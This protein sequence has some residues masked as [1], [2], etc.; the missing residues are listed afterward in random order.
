MLTCLLTCLRSKDGTEGPQAGPHVDQATWWAMHPRVPRGQRD[1]AYARGYMDRISGE[2][3]AGNA[4]LRQAEELVRSLTGVKSASVR[5][6][7]DGELAEIRV[8]AEP[9]AA[10]AEIVRNVQ[11]A[12]LARFGISVAAGR[13]IVTVADV[14]GA[15]AGRENGR[16]P[17]ASQG[18]STVRILSRP[19]P[20][21]RLEQVEF[22]REH[23]GQVRCRVTLALDDEVVTGEAEG[24]DAEGMSLEV[25]ARAAV[26]A[27]RALAGPE[28]APLVLDGVSRVDIAGRDHVVAAVQTRQ[29]RMIKV[30]AGAAAVDD[31]AEYAAALAALQATNRW[32]SGRLWSR[33]AG[34]R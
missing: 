7:A 25:A 6:G 33:P 27:M 26:E 21:P 32:V 3:G 2:T 29:G 22:Q 13:I 8:V 18:E 16:R 9:T 14:E 19:D 28:A 30:L 23:P 24:L 10:A 12:L 5:G 17:A 1:S 15:A 34:N 11:S 31:S 20:R 4:S